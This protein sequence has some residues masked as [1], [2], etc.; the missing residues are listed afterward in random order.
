MLPSDE[1]FRLDMQA[2]VRAVAENRARGFHP[3]AVCTDA[4]SSSTGAIDPLE[5][6]ADYCEEEGLWLHVDAAY[7]GFAVVTEK[8]KALLRGIERA[9]SIGLD[10]HK[11]FFQ[12]YETGCLMVKDIR[13]LERAFAV[14]HDILQ[15]SIWGGNHPNFCDRGLQLSRTATGHEGVGIGA[16]LRDGRFSKRRV[17]GNGAG[18]PGR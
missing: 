10:A 17:Q 14:Q 11:L 3:I 7:G 1:H 18:G 12:P 2:L 9:D 16:D 8:G 15:D 4:G 5:A 13:T 6:M